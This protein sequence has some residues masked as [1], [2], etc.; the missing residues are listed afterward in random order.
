M[1]L[2]KTPIALAAIALFSVAPLAAEAAPTVS[3]RAPAA[4]ATITQD[5][6]QTSQCE[7][8]GLRISSV[9]FSLRRSGASAWTTLNTDGG[10]PYRCNLNPRNFPNGQYTLRAVARDSAG[11]TA[12]ATRNITLSGSS[13]PAANTPPSVSL[14]VNATLSGTQ[15]P[16]QASASDNGSVASV[17]FSLSNG[18]TQTLLLRDTTAP[19]Q[20]TFDTTR[21]ANGTY[22]LMAVATDNQGA[23]ASHQRNVT[24][25]NA[26]TQP[27]PTSLPSTGTRAVA[28][29]ESLGLY[30]TPGTNPGNAGCHVRYRR[31][32]ES[33]WREG[34]AMWYDA[35]NS[36]CRGSLV[37]LTPGTDYV[38]QLGLPGQA[39]SRQLTARTWSENFPIARTVHVASGSQQLNITEGGT[40][41][42][43]VLYTP[44]PGTQ[45]V[46]DVN[47]NADYNIAIS[48]PYVIVRGFTLRD[49]TQDGIRLLSGAHDVVIEDNDISGWG[50]SGT[51]SRLGGARATA[52]MGRC[53]SA[54]DP[55]QPPA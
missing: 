19:Y 2:Q 48:A 12:T 44:A 51:G 47:N 42:G 1:K 15:A 33:Q 14:T 17:E 54:R 50:R 8:T 30:W 3:F 4:G 25:S 7:V 43:Y 28:T 45:A 5:I 9:A 55:A 46:I 20:G 11:A 27:P 10:A 37:H 16:Y 29:F 34:L 49:A 24:I 23:R 38:V 26:P 53:S 22:T 32:N 36:E 40:A 18:S 13:T 31:A 39:P 21:Y 6:S 41:S 52:A 35:R